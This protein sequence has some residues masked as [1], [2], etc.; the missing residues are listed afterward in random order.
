MEVYK[1][2][3]IDQE[4]KPGNVKEKDWEEAKVIYLDLILF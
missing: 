1:T 3:L 4:I 2:K